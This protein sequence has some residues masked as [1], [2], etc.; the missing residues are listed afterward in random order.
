MA[1]AALWVLS[2]PSCS[3]IVGPP[4]SGA[5]VLVEVDGEELPVSWEPAELHVLTLLSD[6]LVLSGDHRFRRTRRIL[7]TDLAT[8]SA[9]VIREEWEGSILRQGGSWI[10]LADICAPDSLALCVAPPTVRA[11]GPNLV[12][13]THAPPQGRLLYLP[14]E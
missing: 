14:A 6:S 7:Q 8:G 3:D 10:L 13:R 9:T 4:T 2:G 5:Y 11:Q 1:G 12:V